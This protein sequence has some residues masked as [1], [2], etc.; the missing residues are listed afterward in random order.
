MSGIR[1]D[2]MEDAPYSANDYVTA[3]LIVS[4]AWML[5]LG[6][7]TLHYVSLVQAVSPAPG[8]V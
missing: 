7:A 2:S 8:A 3:P 5:A 4:A 6:I 1:T